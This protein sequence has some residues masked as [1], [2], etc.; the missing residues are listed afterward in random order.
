MVNKRNK[1]QVFTP[2][3]LVKLM[4]NH[5]GYK[6][7]ENIISKH[8]ID[9]SCGDGAFLCE[10][11]ERYIIH[12]QLKQVYKEDIK[13]GIET[14]IH[15]I[16]IDKNVYQKCIHN[17]NE[18]ARKYNIANVKWDIK[19]E[20]AFDNVLF[21]NSMDYVVGNPPYIKVHDLTKEQRIKYKKYC[22]I[23]NGA[24]DIYIG[25]FEIGMRM[26]NKNG[27]L[28]YITPN[29]WTNSLTAFNFRDKIINNKNLVSVIN[30]GHNKI[31][32]NVSTYPL[33]TM[34]SKQT[35]NADIPVYS[36]DNI[37]GVYTTKYLFSNGIDNYNIFGNLYFIRK[38]DA[39]NLKNIKCQ[40]FSSIRP[41]KV[42]NGFATL[43]DKLFVIDENNDK[44]KKE[45]HVIPCLKASNDKL[46]NIIFPYN[47]NNDKPI[48]FDEF[49][50]VEKE[51]VLQ[52]AKELNVDTTKPN[53]YL[54]GRT[55]AISSVKYERISV[56][57]IVKTKEDIKLHKLPKGHG[58]YSGFYMFY[59]GTDETYNKIKSILVS[60]EFINYVKILGRYKSGG[61]YTFKAEELENY[62]NY[63]LLNG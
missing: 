29:S 49:T 15:G 60:D 47:S 16:E 8:I 19:N 27:N 50:D 54:Y 53:W 23:D 26:L 38:Q 30:C 57:N 48:N 9:N 20:D 6:Q 11:V 21:L 14:Y 4:L 36:L 17:L 37:N 22:G 18:V 59:D 2:Q 51:Y 39:E 52:R 10:I 32:K 33:I 62:I 55:Q 13:K 7:S 44:L 1:S 35:N 42:R 28:I 43:K 34:L 5:V 25:F 41:T 12:C 40:V 58:I 63:K 45:K 56:N 46:C 3:W 31:F 24:F 61:Y